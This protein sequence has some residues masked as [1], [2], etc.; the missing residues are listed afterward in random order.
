MSDPLVATT[1]RK[2]GKLYT[3][4]NDAF[5]ISSV[6][7]RAV[8]AVFATVVIASAILFTALS[9]T[10]WNPSLPSVHVRSASLNGNF[11]A[12]NHTVFSSTGASDLLASS[13]GTV[14]NSTSSSS[15]GDVSSSFYNVSSSSVAHSSNVTS[16]TLA[17]VS[18]VS[19]SSSSSTASFVS[20]SSTASQLS[21]ASITSSSQSSTAS[22]ISSSAT[23]SS[24][25]SGLFT[26]SS[27]TISQSSTASA[28][29]KDVLITPTPLTV[30][31]YN[32]TCDIVSSSTACSCAGVPYVSSVAKL[33]GLVLD[34]RAEKALYGSISGSIATVSDMSGQGNNL[35][36]Y[37]LAARPTLIFDPQI[38]N[39]A[40]KFTGSQAM[41]FSTS[42]SLIDS[43]F[44]MCMV[45]A[46][47]STE[48]LQAIFGYVGYN[49]DHPWRFVNSA[50]GTTNRWANQVGTGVARSYLDVTTSN[51]SVVCTWSGGANNAQPPMYLVS[52]PTVGRLN[53]GISV[54]GITSRVS[55]QAAN[56]GIA[57]TGQFLIGGTGDGNLYARIQ[58][59]VAYNRVLSVNERYALET[60]MGQ[61]INKTMNHPSN[62]TAI[63]L[64]QWDVTGFA[65]DYD[66]S[67]EPVTI[68]PEPVWD[69]VT[70]QYYVFYSVWT[71][72]NLRNPAQGWINYATGS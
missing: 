58:R 40:M 52:A 14:A 67:Q 59:I 4:L 24:T 9:V 69:N 7:S 5:R 39:Y 38:G 10:V 51:Y 22:I 64:S 17:P 15:T 12:R 11:T 19:S 61:S 63:A 56:N 62:D 43:A 3:R 47:D 16:S 45:V 31:S 29:A 71:D 65:T 28:P 2:S 44:T 66:G 23:Q 30:R 18:N 68:E 46:M 26:S 25:S 72:D 70:S 20:T 37:G 33:P 1:R 13:T 41:Q 57:F 36:N 6:S 34:L 53:S 32:T 60:L 21:P 42:Y 48:S 50:D 49:G 8:G 27:S 55:V 54:D 35:T